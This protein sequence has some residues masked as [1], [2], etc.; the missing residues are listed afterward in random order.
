VNRKNVIDDLTSMLE[1]EKTEN[2]REIRA[3]ITYYYGYRSGQCSG[4]TKFSEIFT[5]MQ[6]EKLEKV[7]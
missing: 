5:E 6:E 7:K 3:I 4:N 1:G 2:L